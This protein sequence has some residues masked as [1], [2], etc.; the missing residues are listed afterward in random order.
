MRPDKTTYYL[1]IAKAVSARGTCLRRNYGAVIVKDDEIVG[2]GYTGAPRGERNCCD[3]KRC[4]REALG[5]KPGEHYE[6]CRSVH[7]EMNAIISTG[8]QRCLGATI[9]IIGVNV[10]TGEWVANMPCQLC[11]RVITNAGISR[12]E[13]PGH[14]GIVGKEEDDG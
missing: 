3:V 2:T 8:R 6:L 10:K 13:I 9:Y 7:A 5:C 1:N 12:V 14:Y 4:E 11:Q